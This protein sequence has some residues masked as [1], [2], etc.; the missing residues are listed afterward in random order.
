MLFR[1]VKDHIEKENWFAVFIDFLIV[2]LGIFIGFQITEW[3]SNRADAQ[4]YARAVERFKAE[5]QNNIDYLN[6]AEDEFLPYFESVETA[7]DT[8]LT[9]EHSP[10][11][12]EIVQR[13]MNRLRGTWGIQLQT[14]ALEEMRTDPVLLARQSPDIRAMLSQLSSKMALF[15]VESEFIEKKPLEDRMETNP[16]LELG[17]VE[18]SP[19]LNYNGVEFSRRV[20][21]LNLAVPLTEACKNDHLLKSFYTWE[22][23]QGVM[24]L[25]I[26]RIRAELEQSLEVLE[27]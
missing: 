11:N 25:L 2:V 24:P 19:P 1:R 7:I 14:Q 27:N 21:H 22:K 3:N 9:C 15:R 12:L 17:T 4:E 13:G 18:T 8:L 6:R 10:E 20:R 23:W 5:V 26:T 16:I